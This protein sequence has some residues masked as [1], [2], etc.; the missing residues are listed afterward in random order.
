MPEP[1]GELCAVGAMKD[2]GGFGY[3]KHYRLQIGSGLHEKF[4][5]ERSVPLH[6]VPSGEN[7]MDCRVTPMD[8][9]PR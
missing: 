8:G 4:Q 5:L 1:N 7:R 3:F 9:L 2:T 6:F